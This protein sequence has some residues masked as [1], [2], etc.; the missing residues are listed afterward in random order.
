[1]SAITIVDHVYKT[2]SFICYLIALIGK[3]WALRCRYFKWIWPPAR[4]EQRDT[5]VASDVE[6]L[7]TTESAQSGTAMV[8][9]TRVGLEEDYVK[10][11]EREGLCHARE[12]VLSKR[13]ENLERREQL[14][15][16]RED[17]ATRRE[18]FSYRERARAAR[19]VR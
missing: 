18:R 16:E 1:M 8:P 12:E 2:G 5:G 10:V 3:D 6:G 11:R 15:K 7:P 14:L 4:E 9:L 17:A 13:E 19:R